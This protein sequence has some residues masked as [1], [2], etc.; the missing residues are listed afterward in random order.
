MNKLYINDQILSTSGPLYISRNADAEEARIEIGQGRTANGYAYI[1]LIGDTTYT[2]YGLRIIRNNSGENADSLIRHRGTGSP[3]LDV[4][5]KGF[6]SIKTNGSER[7]RINSSGNVCIG[8]TDDGGYKLRVNGSMRLSG[9]IRPA[10]LYT[11][12]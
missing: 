9:G 6:L 8:T 3:V 2:D 12:S 10:V 7:M 11:L 4:L 5:D 1:N